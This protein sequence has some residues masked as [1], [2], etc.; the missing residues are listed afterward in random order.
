MSGVANQLRAVQVDLAASKAQLA[1][2]LLLYGKLLGVY[3]E[4]EGAAAP[5]PPALRRA[6]A[7]AAR[8]AAA[9]A[10]GRSEL[11]LFDEEEKSAAGMFGSR[12]G[13]DEA[14]APSQV[15]GMA[16]EARPLACK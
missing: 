1:R 13:G 5:P 14:M 16:R 15:E 10:S 7:T 4:A 9:A 12:G 8:A 2:T 11:S 6:R 3:G